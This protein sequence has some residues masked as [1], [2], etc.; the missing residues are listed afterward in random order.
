MSTEPERLARLEER[1]TRAETDIMSLRVTTVSTEVF[2]ARMQNV[3]LKLEG[4]GGV[5]KEIK[6]DIARRGTIRGGL[7]MP[8][9]VSLSSGLT[10][11]L[12]TYF[13]SH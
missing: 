1:V 9:S 10:V 7:L 2:A 3:D 8:L 13:L 11:T 5:L 4:I 12:V 6:D